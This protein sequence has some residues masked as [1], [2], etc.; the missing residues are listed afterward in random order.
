[1]VEASEKDRIFTAT[2]QHPIKRHATTDDHEKKRPRLDERTDFSRWRM[3]D[4]AGRHT[5][6]YLEDDEE[7]EKWPQS[8]ADKYFLGLPM[9]RTACLLFDCLWGA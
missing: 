7:N 3:R 1:M 6:H 2:H 9:V 4:D 5:W 8:Y